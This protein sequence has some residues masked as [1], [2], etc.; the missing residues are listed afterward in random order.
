MCQMAQER[1]SRLHMAL[2]IAIA[3]ARVAVARCALQV[4]R[5]RPRPTSGFPHWSYLHPSLGHSVLKYIL[6]F[7]VIPSVI[8]HFDEYNAALMEPLGESLAS[9]AKQV[10]PASLTC[11]NAVYS[12]HC[13]PSTAVT[14]NHLEKLAHVIAACMGNM[15]IAHKGANWQ[16]EK[17]AELLEA[18]LVFVWYSLGEEIA[19][20]V[21]FKPVQED[22]KDLY[23]YEIQV[24]EKCQLM[25]WGRQLMASFHAVAKLADEKKNDPHLAQS[26]HLAM[27]GTS[28]TVFGDNHRA[29]EW[30]TRLGY[31]LA[32]GSP[33]CRRLRSGA[34]IRPDYFLLT[35]SL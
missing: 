33:Q 17:L 8:M 2:R 12:R 7:I 34:V 35:R 22:R 29:F 9:L 21:A 32:P 23:L 16:E 10:F 25:Q 27:E 19:A 11:R 18:G 1:A 26:E 6:Q 30:Y 31:V 14:I 20:F 24:I 3:I 5:F 4:C 28:L 13:F 15:Y